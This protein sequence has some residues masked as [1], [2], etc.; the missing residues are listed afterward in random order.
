[1]PNIAT[2]T[3]HGGTTRSRLSALGLL[4]IATIVIGYYES[5][6]AAHP[7]L[8][9]R[10]PEFHWQALLRSS[11]IA[12]VCCAFILL[13]VRADS[14]KRWS[15]IDKHNKRDRLL[16]F[17]TLASA[18][19][20]VSILSWSPKLFFR[21]AVEDGVVEYLSAVFLLL[22]SWS[23][24]MTSRRLSKNTSVD[25]LVQIGF[26][27]LALVVFIIGMEEI[28]W[29]QRI[30]GYATPTAFDANWQGEMNFHNFS[31]NVSE[32]A[33]YFGSW[34]FLVLVPLLFLN[35]P[36]HHKASKLIGPFLASSPIILIA[37]I[38]AAFNFDMWNIVFSQIA[39]LMSVSICVYALMAINNINLSTSVFLVL[40]V[41]LTIQIS[42]FH[43]GD[44]MLRSYGAT[45]YRELF[46]AWSLW[47][48]AL[49][50]RKQL[51]NG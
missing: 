4:I 7:L 40:F 14:I 33:Y 36:S 11:V 27:A 49:D 48:Y 47:L 1:M 29:M 21:L 24:W 9:E 50:R 17:I 16:I 18:T 6:L 13:W 51:A 34:L 31:T 23:L 12:I 25:R 46:I 15:V 26:I 20:F 3:S 44:S 30:F 38:P 42:F 19:L 28:S 2:L 35:Q 32:N 43:L 41:L 22:S 39:Y 8:S 5:Q 37:M 10:P 45:E